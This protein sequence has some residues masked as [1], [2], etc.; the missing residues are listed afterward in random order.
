MSGVQL[1]AAH[2]AEVAAGDA[3][4]VEL[5]EL[6]QDVGVSTRSVQ[7]AVDRM[8]DAGV[9]AGARGRYR[10]LDGAWLQDLASGHKTIGHD[11]TR[12]KAKVLRSK[13][14]RLEDVCEGLAQLV[15]EVA[16]LRAEVAALRAVG[17]VTEPA[18]PAPASAPPL[19]AL[20]APSLDDAP[21]LPPRSLDDTPAPPASSL[22]SAVTKGR[23]SRGTEDM[24]ELVRLVERARDKRGKQG[25]VSGAAQLLGVTEGGVR[26][27][28][29][30]GRVTPDVAAR[31]ASA[32]AR[33]DAAE[34]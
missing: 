21:A 33:L 28:L 30:A 5:W 19:P 8:R 2:F 6:A 12:A 16:S 24:A 4:R 14:V 26:A 27:A 11:T 7:R 29:R 13:R 22:P 25:S 18:P 32:H 15:A 9:I 31:V 1:V 34:G 3:V 23:G 10:I 17:G 20:D